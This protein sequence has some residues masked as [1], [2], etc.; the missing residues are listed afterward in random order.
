MCIFKHLLFRL[1]IT[2]GCR[3]CTCP[4]IRVCVVC[5]GLCVGLC[6]WCVVWRGL[7]RGKTSVCRFKTSPCASSKRFRVC[8]QNARMLNMRA[9]CRYKRKRFEPTHGHV[10][11]PHTERRKGEK[12]GSLPSLSRP[13]S[14]YLFL[15]L[16]LFRRSLHSF[17]FSFSSPSL[18][19]SLSVTMTMITRPVGSL[20]VHTALTCQSV[21]VRGPWP[22]PWPI[23]CWPNMF[24]SC[25]KQLSWQNCASFVPLGMKWACIC[26]GN[27]CCV[28]VVFGCVSMW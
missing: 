9:F 23:P 27:R 18:F 3:L 11:N 2:V 4:N 25:K 13:F 24:G 16:S 28:L 20:C 26:A 14:L 7:A 10:S 19:S 8:Q 1:K 17:S 21:R 12:G 15:L 22:I 6:L 5:V